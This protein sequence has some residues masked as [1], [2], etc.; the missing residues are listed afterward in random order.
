MFQTCT[1]Q[2]GPVPAAY[3]NLGLGQDAFISVESFPDELAGGALFQYFLG[4][5][6]NQYTITR[7][8]ATSPYGSPYIDGI[9][10]TWFVGAYGNTC[11]PFM[12]DNG[13]GFSF[14]G[15]PCSVTIDQTS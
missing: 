1:L 14:T 9:L 11:S 13:T 10:Y 4:C 3:A 8:Y 2:Y 15:E 7:I 5:L 12:L 6:Q